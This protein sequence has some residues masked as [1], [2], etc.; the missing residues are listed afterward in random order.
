MRDD[1]RHLDEL[2]R[3]TAAE[4]AAR[5]AR[6]AR[7]RRRDTEI[8]RRLATMEEEARR[9]ASA[10]TVEAGY[11]RTATAEDWRIWVDHRR[12]ALLREQA[13]VRAEIEGETAGL[14]RSFGRDYA[15][16]ELIGRTTRE[17]RQVTA[18]RE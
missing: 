4:F 6:V 13:R 17:R 16:R 3:L 5:Q 18:R 1:P 10:L 15:I 12:R 7:L 2:A 9:Q 8:A 14:A 11:Q